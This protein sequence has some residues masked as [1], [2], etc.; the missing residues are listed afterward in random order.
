LNPERPKDEGEITEEQFKEL[1]DQVQ[2]L[3]AENFVKKMELM[4]IRNFRET[5]ESEKI[6]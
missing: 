6:V 3:K 1:K 2:A 5:F 4:N